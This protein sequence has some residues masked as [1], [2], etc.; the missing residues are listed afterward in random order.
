MGESEY[1][2]RANN[3]QERLVFEGEQCKKVKKCMSKQDNDYNNEEN[4]TRM[5]ATTGTRMYRA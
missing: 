2:Q 1:C 4:S 3:E 5:Q